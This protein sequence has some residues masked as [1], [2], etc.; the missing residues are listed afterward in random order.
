VITDP[1]SAP[2][3]H[4]A[5]FRYYHDRAIAIRARLPVVEDDEAFIELYLLAAYYERL[6]EFVESSGPLACIKD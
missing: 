3:R 1:A 5:Q 6:A 2:S 4:S